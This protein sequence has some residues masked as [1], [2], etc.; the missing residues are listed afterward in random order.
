MPTNP[1]SG[2]KPFPLNVRDKLVR[3]SLDAIHAAD[4]AIGIMSLKGRIV[5]K[6]VVHNKH[7]MLVN[8]VREDSTAAMRCS[9]GRSVFGPDP[10]IIFR[11]NAKCEPCRDLFSD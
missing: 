5:G 1:K 7:S 10:M 3:V 11:I 8:P 9:L 6:V 4:T 2:K